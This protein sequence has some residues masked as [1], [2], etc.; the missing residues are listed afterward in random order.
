MQGALGLLRPA[1]HALKNPRC[2]P[3]RASPK[4]RE[5]PAGASGGRWRS[6]NPH[7]SCRGKR[8]V[9]PHRLWPAP[10]AGRTGV[11][12]T[13]PGPAR[14]LGLPR[15]RPRAVFLIATTAARP[16]AGFRQVAA[17][18]PGRSRGQCV[19]PGGLGDLRTP[20]RTPA[21][22]RAFGQPNLR[23]RGAPALLACRF[24][25]RSKRARNGLQECVLRVE[26]PATT[27]TTKIPCSAGWRARQ[28]AR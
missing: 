1:C 21:P 12:A 4:L 10:R 28:R 25:F 5:G 20:P 14:T 8:D 2:L 6:G 7:R 13:R 16:I 23:L 3:P 19:G 22:L 17:R 18:A 9:H 26:A 11:A 24:A 27:T 15:D